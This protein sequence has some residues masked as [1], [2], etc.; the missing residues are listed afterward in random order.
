MAKLKIAGTW[1]GVLE[2]VELDSWTIPMLREEVAKRSNCAPESINLICAGKVLKD[3]DDDGVQNLTQ[4][5]IKNNSKIL[6]TRVTTP[7]EGNSLKQHMIAEEERSNRLSRIR[8]V[9]IKQLIC[10]FWDS[11]CIILF[12]WCMGFHKNSNFC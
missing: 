12:V 10:F 9:K 7:S 2:E 8:Y 4:L 11:F 1:A 6:A 5:G 3:G